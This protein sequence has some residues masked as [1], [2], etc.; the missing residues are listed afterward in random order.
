MLQELSGDIQ[1]IIVTHNRTS[2]SV[3]D[4]LYGIT[5]EEAGAS[6]VLSMQLVEA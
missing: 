6:K 1:F 2:M 3:A 5:M 4:Y